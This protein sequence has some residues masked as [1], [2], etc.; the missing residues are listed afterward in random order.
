MNLEERL[1]LALMTELGLYGLENDALVERI[2]AECP[3]IAGFWESEWIPEPLWASVEEV[4]R[5]R[6]EK[7]K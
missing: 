3:L 2:K 4:V 1:R 5:T 6:K 7:G